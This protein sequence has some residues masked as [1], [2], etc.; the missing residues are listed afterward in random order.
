MNN[1]EAMKLCLSLL[2]ADTEQEVKDI[3]AKAGYW[4]DPKCWRLYGDKDQNFAQGG[5]QQSRSEAALVE[6]IIN[7][8]DARLMNE[9]LVR[10]VDPKSSDA[11]QSIQ[12]AVSAFFSP[13]KGTGSLGGSLKDWPAAIRREQAKFITIAAT[14]AKKRPSLT[15]TDQGEGQSPAMMPDTLLSLDKK[16][17]L[18]IHFVQGKF[19]MGGTGV[20]RFCGS[21]SIELV[22]SRRNP[23]IVPSKGDSST[24]IWGFTVVRR[25]RPVEAAGSV[26]NSVY[27]YLAPEGAVDSTTKGRVLSF[28]SPTLAVMPDGNN[29]YVREISWG[30]VIKLYEYDM[31]GFS[32]NVLMK[33]GL[34]YRLEVLLPE[35]ALP[36]RMHECRDFRG[37]EGSFETNMAGLCTRL[38]D[39]KGDNLESGFPDSVPFS[40]HGQKFIAR[41]YAFKKGKAETYRTNEGVILSLN[42]QTHG[43]FPK[44]FFERKSVRMDRIADSLLVMVDC[45]NIDVATREDLF[46]ASRDRMS[47]GEFRKDIERELEEI[48]S[49]HQALRELRDRRKEQEIANR[50]EDSKPLEAI[51]DNL[52]KMSPTL[53]QLFLKGQRLHNPHK[54]ETIPGQGPEGGKDY[55]GK[56]HPTF[57]RFEEFEDGAT[58]KRN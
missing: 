39:G 13:S 4:D 29:A 15:I 10:G 19:N 24:A 57:F 5:N 27:T 34:L 58:L 36:V 47:Q 52:I 53:S 40:V 11:P 16:N 48:I 54:K 37:K 20:L 46:M 44:T 6:K 21:D 17:K 49:Q 3:L 31:K 18:Q 23:K 56:P 25:E 14:G 41:I 30:T 2:H 22:I 33:D 9:C 45:S 35:I 28:S 51:L 26:R 1:Q 8:V 32:S 42:G 43:T 7:S 50:L 38:E 55:K 12:D